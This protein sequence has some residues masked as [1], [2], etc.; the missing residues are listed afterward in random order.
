M[1]PCCTA[2]WSF[3]S[4]ERKLFNRTCSSLVLSFAIPRSTMDLL[5]WMHTYRSKFS[6][7]RFD[8]CRDLSSVLDGS[9]SHLLAGSTGFS[10][11]CACAAELSGGGVSFGLRW[12][13]SKHLGISFVP[14]SETLRPFFVSGGLVFRT[15]C[16]ISFKGHTIDFCLSSTFV[17]PVGPR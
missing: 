15:V 10:G 5:G 4:F 8:T 9:V 14:L 16:S 6:H 2:I 1:G 11:C 7:Q 17:R 13:G 12:R 3:S